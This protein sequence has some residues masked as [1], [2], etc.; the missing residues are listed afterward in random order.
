MM[1][2]RDRS[3]ILKLYYTYIT[4]VRHFV[5]FDGCFLFFSLHK[6]K[7]K[8]TKRKTKTKLKIEINSLVHFLFRILSMI[9]II[10]LKLRLNHSLYEAIDYRFLNHLRINIFIHIH[11]HTHKTH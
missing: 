7:R 2:V 4:C 6:Q 10:K 5:T 1:V 11:T 9:T 8:V 3:E